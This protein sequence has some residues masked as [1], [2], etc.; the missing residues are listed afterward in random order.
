MSFKEAAAE[1]I[2]EMTKDA[3]W[4][5]EPLVGFADVSSPKI[6]GLKESV[7]KDHLLPEEV[8]PEA[9]PD[10]VGSTLEVQ[11]PV[12][13]PVPEEAG[14]RA[15]VRMPPMAVQVV[16]AKILWVHL[17]ISPEPAREV[18]GTAPMPTAVPEEAGS[19]VTAAMP[20]TRQAATLMDAAE[21]VD[22]VQTAA[23]PTA[24]RP[25]AEEAAM[26]VKAEMPVLAVAEAAVMVPPGTAVT[27]ANPAVLLPEAEP[28]LLADPAVSS[29]NTLP[30]R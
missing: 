2:R 28:T 18:S 15:L 10:A 16:Q 24:R 21:A 3:D 6:R 25:E 1:I 11:V 9:V 22:M 4:I 30:T 17:Q 20:T 5:R 27:A 29:S 14:I 7:A 26:A 19:A 8:L 13:L 12:V 23:T